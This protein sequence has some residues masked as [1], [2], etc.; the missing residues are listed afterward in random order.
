[1][2]TEWNG[3]LTLD[4]RL[5][6]LLQRIIALKKDSPEEAWNECQDEL[7]EHDGFISNDSV[8]GAF[9]SGRWTFLHHAVYHNA[10]FSTLERMNEQKFVRSLR[11]SEGK[12]PVD[13]LS[14]DASEEYRALVTPVYKIE[15]IDW[16]K[17]RKIEEHFHQVILNRAEQL[18]KDHHLILPM[19]SVFL[20]ATTED[21]EWY[22]GVPGMYGGFTMTLEYNNV[23]NDVVALNTSSWCRVAGGSGQSHCCTADGWEL[24]DEGFV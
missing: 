9:P 4:D 23:N 19:L 22:F 8:A 20:E 2:F 12:M 10:P 18:V 7:D 14:A 1:M 24:N 16:T 11:D 13:Y 3:C 21:N 17:L 6:E 5:T 15:N